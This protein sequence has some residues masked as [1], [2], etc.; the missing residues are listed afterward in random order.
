MLIN[1]TTK[2]K[3]KA[4]QQITLLRK[5]KKRIIIIIN[6]NNNLTLN[7]WL[8]C[9]CAIKYYITLIYLLFVEVKLKVVI[10]QYLKFL[11]C[12]FLEGTSELL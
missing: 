5:T 3:Q 6:S 8:N 10:Y 9:D 2:P 4:S 11:S 7:M 12:L 1:R